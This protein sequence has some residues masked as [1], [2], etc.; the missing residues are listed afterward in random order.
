MSATY[1]PVYQLSEAS[2]PTSSDYFVF[3]SSA[4]GGDVGLLPISTFIS[5]FI[6]ATIDSVAIDSTTID[7]YTA[8]GWTDPGE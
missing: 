4:T 5:T 2:S 6:Q 3:Q 7:T 1:L 8:M